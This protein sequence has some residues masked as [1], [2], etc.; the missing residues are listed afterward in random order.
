M[1][2]I[3][4][5]TGHRP[6][7][8]N[9]YEAKDNKELLWA[10]HERIEKLILENKANVFISGMALG[11]DTWA[12]LSVLKLKEKYPYI[13]LI[14]AIPCKDHSSKWVASSKKLWKEITSKADKVVYV[15]EEPFTKWCM[16]AR[17]VWMCDN[18]NMV[19]SVWD[20]TEGG[21]ANCVAY[22][23]KIGKFTINIDPTKYK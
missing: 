20:G 19:L 10:L 7:S 12:A 1:N 16:Q 21:T 2:Y 11:I 3:V 15:S 9:G 14:C 5:F 22:A 17:N 23:T 6:A 18:C 4:A 8:L 13:K